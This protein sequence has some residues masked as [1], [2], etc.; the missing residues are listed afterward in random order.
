[1]SAEPNS[2]FKS[3]KAIG[4]GPCQSSRNPT[5]LSWDPVSEAGKVQTKH[6]PLVAIASFI[7][8]QVTFHT[9]LQLRQHAMNSTKTISGLSYGFGLLTHAAT[10]MEAPL[11]KSTRLPALI[12]LVFRLYDA[13][14]FPKVVLALL[15]VGKLC[16]RHL[17]CSARPNPLTALTFG[18]NL[19]PQ[20]SCSNLSVDPPA[21]HTP[22]GSDHSVASCQVLFCSFHPPPRTRRKPQGRGHPSSWCPTARIY[23][24]YIRSPSPDHTQHIVV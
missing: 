5:Q 9:A 20:L 18:S 17:R 21:A 22:T 24:Q 7:R 3:A 23:Q 14:N 15:L 6:P 4:R 10:P 2:W 8:L 13:R 16:S 19:Q 1:M 12:S 11:T